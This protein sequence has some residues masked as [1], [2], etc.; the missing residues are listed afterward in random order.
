[1]LRH[2][3]I[4][5]IWY[6]LKKLSVVVYTLLL[7]LFTQL[8]LVTSHVILSQF[9]GWT[10]ALEMHKTQTRIQNPVEHPRWSFLQKLWTVESNYLFA[11]SS[12]L[13][14]CLCSECT[15]KTYRQTLFVR[16]KK[17]SV[18]KFIMFCPSFSL[19]MYEFQDDKIS[20]LFIPH[21][22][23]GFKRIIYLVRVKGV[24]STS[25]FMFHLIYFSKHFIVRV[26]FYF[27]QLT[28]RPTHLIYH[29]PSH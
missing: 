17:M 4:F 26:S 18:L 25:L 12:I 7:S 3:N 6:S 11:K 22:V 27:L 23:W 8:T 28:V 13:D 2:C 14:V 1:M 20:F 10:D 15:S 24:T 9:S 29:S 5:P 21:L 19:E 16:E